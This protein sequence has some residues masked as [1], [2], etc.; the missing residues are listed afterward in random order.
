MTMKYQ[1]V[2]VALRTPT[3]AAGGGDVVSLANLPGTIDGRTAHIA[4]IV[5]DIVATAAYT[6]A[7]TIQG[8][9]SLISQ[10]TFF[11]G[12]MERYVGSLFDLRLH[13]VIENGGKLVFP[14]VELDGGTGSVFAFRRYLPIGAL[15]WADPADGLLP[16]AS[17][18][19][20]ELRFTF[21]ATTDFSPNATAIT[22]V[23]IS[24]TAM[25]YP[26]DGQ[27]LIA[28]ALERRSIAYNSDNPINGEAVY[29]DLF[30]TAV[31][32]T[33][34]FT[35]GQLATVKF[36]TGNIATPAMFPSTLTAMQSLYG[37]QGPISQL[38]GEPRAATDTGPKQVDLGTPT[39]LS[40]VS[41]IQQ[42]VVPASAGQS[43]TKLPYYTPSGCKVTWTGSAAATQLQAHWARILA[44]PQ[45]QIARYAAEAA[46]K[47]GRMPK[48]GEPRTM[49][50]KPFNGGQRWA[51]FLPFMYNI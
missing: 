31:N 17:M 38:Q 10:M 24:L 25:C 13:E 33:T 49:S 51:Q 9:H 50:K 27:L 29:N 20:A 37:R 28:P 39:A 36:D 22:L 19:N 43:I 23:N 8:V 7:P 41:A 16:A 35:A 21:G 6:T 5:I 47:M 14:D 12:I 15:N 44:Q 18:S 34:A 1:A 45:A 4:G 42:V 48:S 46:K 3:Y 2:P 32:R 11:D 40:N 26:R 30:L